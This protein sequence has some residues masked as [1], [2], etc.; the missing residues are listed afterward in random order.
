LRRIGEFTLIAREGQI[1][2]VPPEENEQQND[3]DYAKAV[4]PGG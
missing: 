2:A 3:A 4:A 1:K